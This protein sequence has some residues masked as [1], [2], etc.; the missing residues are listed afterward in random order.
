MLVVV[1]GLPVPQVRNMLHD[2]AAA[3]TSA[4]TPTD[5]VE[6]DDLV[7]VAAHAIST[8]ATHSLVLVAYAA[9]DWARVLERSGAAFAYLHADPMAFVAGHESLL[10]GTRTV[11]MRLASFVEPQASGICQTIDA[12]A[13]QATEEL[14]KFVGSRLGLRDLSLGSVRPESEISGREGQSEQNRELDA[15][16]RAVLRSFDGLREG[17]RPRSVLTSRLLFHD[18]TRDGAAV[19]R[20]IDA[21]G[22]ARIL[23]YGPYAYLPR[24]IW[25]ARTVVAF[26]EQLVGQTFGIEITAGFGTNTLAQAT[27]NIEVPGRRDMVVEFKHEDASAPVEVR[28]SSQRG[29]FDGTLSLGYVEFS[30]AE[31]DTQPIVAPLVEEPLSS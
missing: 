29:V 9:Q 28:F 10:D 25:R 21:T 2:V 15:T 18:A 31:P 17:V 19:D 5:V 20:A 12:A 6:V 8:Q 3:L 22:R 23:F 16:V 11:M 7:G 26:A 1:L 13:P 24:G 14:L 27:F 4:G 30:V